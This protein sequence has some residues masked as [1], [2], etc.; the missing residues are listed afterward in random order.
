MR[1]QP[2]SG[3]LCSGGLRVNMFTDDELDDIHLATLEVLERTGVFVEDD[4][5]REVLAG[6]GA[7]VDDAGVV[8]IPGHVVDEAIASAPSRVVCCGRDPADDTVLEA[9]R[10]SFCNFGQ[11]VLVVDADG[12]LRPSGIDDLE[13]TAR[14]VDALPEMD[15]L[16]GTVAAPDVPVVTANLHRAERLMTGC[17]KHALLAPGSARIAALTRA[18][19][20]VA[21]GYGSLDELRRRP[22]V[23]HVVCPVSPL[24]LIAEVTSV[25]IDAAREGIPVNVVSMALGGVTAPIRLAGAIVQSNAEVLACIVLAQLTAKGAPVI[26]GSST[27]ASDLRYGSASVG[28]PECALISAGLAAV[29]RRYRLPSVLAGL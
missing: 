11:A 27:T 26:Y 17:S 25:I 7:R 9:G 5:A 14:L 3:H 19:A 28:S 1:R 15:I 4:E 24:R 22:T 6:G 16:M 8:R 23:T 18:M 13:D 2:R 20:A 12:V 10:V 21:A 29:A